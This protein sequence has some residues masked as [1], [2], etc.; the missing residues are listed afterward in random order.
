MKRK[1]KQPPRATRAFVR[2]LARSVAASSLRL[3]R[4]KQKTL[5]SMI[6]AVA[7]ARENFLQVVQEQQNVKKTKPS[8][9]RTAPRAPNTTTET[10]PLGSAP[11]GFAIQVYPRTRLAAQSLFLSKE[12]KVPCSVKRAMSLAHFS[13]EE[14]NNKSLQR[15]IERFKNKMAR[16]PPA[17]IETAPTVE[18]IANG[19]SGLSSSKFGSR[20][21]SNNKNIITLSSRTYGTSE[22]GTASESSVSA[23]VD[24]LLVKRR[25]TSNKFILKWSRR[26]LQ[27]WSRSRHTWSPLNK[28]RTTRDPKSKR[29]LIKSID[30]IILL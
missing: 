23:F 21:S 13:E 19:I 11:N 15:R 4:T 7:K 22:R 24:G 29:L 10:V 1:A 18:A 14:A 12:S 9:T 30:F 20:G 26:S 2:L 3:T 17:I 5:H 25:R 6:V 16:G 8:P 28:S 27:R